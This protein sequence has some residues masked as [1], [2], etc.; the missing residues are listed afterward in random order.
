MEHKLSTIDRP[1][2]EQPSYKFYQCVES[3]FYQQLGCQFPWN[4]YKDMK[5]PVCNTLSQLSNVLEQSTMNRSLGMDR[6][7]WTN[8]DRH[9]YTN[10]KCTRPC[11]V[12]SYQL[13]YEVKTSDYV[14]NTWDFDIAFKNFKFEQKV[15]FL[16]CDGTCVIGEL[17][18]NLGFFLGGSILALIDF[19]ANIFAYLQRKWINENNIERNE[20]N[21][22]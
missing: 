8:Q 18:G 5:V 1:C 13:K 10:G 14:N 6:E 2:Q 12:T 22:I 20:M 7:W 9:L 4:V 21:P 3:H 19:I 17:G 16:V 11:N 15:E